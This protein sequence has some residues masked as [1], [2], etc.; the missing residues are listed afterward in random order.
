MGGKRRHTSK[1][2]GYKKGHTSS[3]KGKKLDYEQNS[4][5]EPFMRLKHDIFESRVTQDSDEVLTIMDVNQSHCPPMLLRS[6]LK[7]PEVLDD[8]LEST[9]CCDGELKF[10]SIASKK[11]EFAWIEGLKCKN[12][13]GQ[14]HKL[15]Y[16]ID[17]R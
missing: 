9:C 12:F 1:I 7:S 4:S 11:C 10:D 2:F 16:E 5:S 13:V 3:H 8:Y 6:R 14:Y 15:Y 17:T